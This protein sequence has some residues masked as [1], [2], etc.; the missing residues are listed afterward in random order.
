MAKHP[1]ENLMTTLKK[2]VFHPLHPAGYPFVVGGIIATFFGYLLWDFIGFVFLCF[3]LFSLYFFRDP[4]RVTPVGDNLVI[5]PADGRVCTI[6]RDCTLPA[7]IAPDGERDKIYTRVSIFLSAIDVHVNRNP[8]S[9]TVLK[10]AYVPGR[11]INAAADEA[12]EQNERALV[13]L[14]STNGALIG[15]SQVAGLIARRIVTEHEEGKEI[16]AGQK[17]GLIRF[18]SRTDIYLPEGIEPLVCEDQRCI[19]GETVIANLSGEQRPR[20]GKTNA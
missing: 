13:L 20:T 1:N 7:E 12:S 8:V 19:G 6:R 15:L 16:I 3:T 2:T 9:G 18:G 11:Y 5:S 10:T 17:F 4:P 14:K